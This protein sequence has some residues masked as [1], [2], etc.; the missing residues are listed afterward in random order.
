MINLTFADR[1]F[2]SLFWFLVSPL[3]YLLYL[4]ALCALRFHFRCWLAGSSALRS[5]RCCGGLGS[6]LAGDEQARHR[7]IGLRRT[8]VSRARVRLGCL[9]THQPWKS[10]A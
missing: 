7:S 8:D 5:R 9:P 6:R 3:V 2:L 4:L 1:S 10:T